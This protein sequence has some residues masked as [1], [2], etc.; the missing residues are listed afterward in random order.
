MESGYMYMTDTL[1]TAGALWD[2]QWGS[3]SHPIG[4]A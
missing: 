1:K 2:Y 3:R 4:L